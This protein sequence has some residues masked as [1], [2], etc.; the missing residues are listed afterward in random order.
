MASTFLRF[1]RPLARTITSGC[2]ALRGHTKG[3][4]PSIVYEWFSAQRWTFLRWQCIENIVFS[5]HWRNYH[6]GRP[7]RLRIGDALRTD[8][9]QLRWSEPNIDHKVRIQLLS[10]AFSSL[11]HLQKWTVSDDYRATRTTFIL[12]HSN[13]QQG[14][15]WRYSS[16]LSV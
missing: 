5:R 14:L 16:N 8:R 1:L 2:G 3:V 9:I 10:V 12:R 4:H 15:L 6:F 11:S 13:H 7:V